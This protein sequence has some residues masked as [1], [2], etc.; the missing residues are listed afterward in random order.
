MV[1][2]LPIVS[3][4]V[5][6]C[7]FVT[8]FLSFKR[9]K[10]YWYELLSRLY[11]CLIFEFHWFDC[12][13]NRWENLFVLFTMEIV[14]LVKVFL[15]YMYLEIQTQVKPSTEIC[16]KGLVLVESVFWIGPSLYVFCVTIPNNRDFKI[17]ILLVYNIYCTAYYASWLKKSIL[18]NQ[19]LL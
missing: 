2:S 15:V 5:S 12:G 9:S 14:K 3:Q 11:D 16:S 8:I 1:L 17:S 6:D 19:V 10:H 13:F 4:L 18:V 7:I